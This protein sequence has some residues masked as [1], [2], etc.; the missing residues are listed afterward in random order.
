M[1][2]RRRRQTPMKHDIM[3]FN[4]WV[5]VS[6]NSR[7]SAAAVPTRSREGGG[8]GGHSRTALKAIKFYLNWMFSK[9][10]L[11]KDVVALVA[12]YAK[13]EFEQVK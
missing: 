9:K 13:V 7:M 1:P 10:V 5:Q 4:E 2:C 3:I 11:P 8:G 6:S 12:E